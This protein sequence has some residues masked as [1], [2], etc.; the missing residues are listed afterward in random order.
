MLLY[1]FKSQKGFVIQ[2][3]T[4]EQGTWTQVAS[5]D[6]DAACETVQHTMV[7]FLS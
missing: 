6:S 3:I 2:V 1:V 5:V 4:T 7:V